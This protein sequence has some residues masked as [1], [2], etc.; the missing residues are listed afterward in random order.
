MA[1]SEVGRCR[2]YVRKAYNSGH[3]E[4]AKK[5]LFLSSIHLKDR[6]TVPL[7]FGR[8]DFLSTY[9]IDQV[10][11]FEIDQMRPLFII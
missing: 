5:R 3:R 11:S 6:P 9:R 2:T 10:F 7:F 8:Q 1:Q 4:L